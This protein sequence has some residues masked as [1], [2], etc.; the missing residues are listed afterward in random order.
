MSYP[1]QSGHGCIGCSEKG[2]WDNDTF[3][4]R[5]DDV[6]LPNT[7]TTADTIG[8]AAA[9]AATGAVI[10]HGAATIAKSRLKDY[11]DEKK[12]RQEGTWDDNGPTDKGGNH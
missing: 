3:Y 7:I 2:F 4:K 10:V 9:F 11:K 8:T 12:M 5:L 6:A 1:I